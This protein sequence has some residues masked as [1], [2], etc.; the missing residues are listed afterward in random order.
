M[1]W[2]PGNLIVRANYLAAVVFAMSLASFAAAIA[3]GEALGGAT[4]SWASIPTILLLTVLYVL[5]GA[6]ALRRVF[7]QGTVIPPALVH[8]RPVVAWVVTLAGG[9]GHVFFIVVMSVVIELVAGAEFP[10]DGG[11]PMT[12]F[13]GLTMLPYLISLFCAEFVLVGDGISDAKKMGSDPVS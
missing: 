6:R 3:L 9:V 7:D 13:I 8:E 1:S 5:P 2:G 4:S 12:F 10:D 11:G